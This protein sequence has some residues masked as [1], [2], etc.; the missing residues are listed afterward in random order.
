[1]ADNEF[2]SNF[3]I[4]PKRFFVIKLKPPFNTVGSFSEVRFRGCHYETEDP[5]PSDVSKKLDSYI[6]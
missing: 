5:V 6:F 1:M 4:A 3:V 2:L